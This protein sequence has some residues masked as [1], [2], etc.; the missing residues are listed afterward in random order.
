MSSLCLGSVN[1]AHF[2]VG[3][4]PAQHFSW[5]DDDGLTPGVL[6]VGVPTQL[7]PRNLFLGGQLILQTTYHRPLHRVSTR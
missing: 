5:L 1:P 2:T 4:N 6:V 7:L 3:V